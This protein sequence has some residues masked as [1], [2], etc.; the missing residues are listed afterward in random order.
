VQV[1]LAQTGHWL[2]SLGRVEG[3]ASIQPPAVEA[4]TEVSSSG[5]GELTAIRHSAILSR[6]PAQWT[7]PSVSPGYSAPHW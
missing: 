3:A 7:R 5:F 2:R 4:F 6:T 1:S